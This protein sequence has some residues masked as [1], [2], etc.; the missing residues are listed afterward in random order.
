MGGGEQPPTKSISDYV[1]ALFS[2][3]IT[4]GLRN[5]PTLVDFAEAG[6]VSARHRCVAALC[7]VGERWEG[8]WRFW[9]SAQRRLRF[10]SDFSHGSA[11]KASVPKRGGRASK[12]AGG[13]RPKSAHGPTEAD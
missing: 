7:C 10:R 13:E 11:P 3:Y 6:W 8:G 4:V 12:M 1:E 9:N 5:D 2:L